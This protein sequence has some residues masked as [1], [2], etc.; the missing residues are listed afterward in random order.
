MYDCTPLKTKCADK[1]KVHDYCEEKLG[2]DICVPIIKIYNKTDEI[3]WEELPD[4]FVIKC[5]HGSGMNIIVKDKKLLNKQDAV[6]KLNIWMRTDFAFQNGY[7]Y[8]YHDIER[9]IFAESFIGKDKGDLVDYKFSC[10][11]GVPKILQVM[12]DRYSGRLRLN[13]YDMDFKPLYCSRNDHPANYNITDEKPNGFDLMVGYSKI[14]SKDFK[15]VR[16]DFYEVNGVVYLGELTF[17]PGS[18]FFKYNDDK[19]SL[20]FGEWL[21]LNKN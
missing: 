19:W 4:R 13:Y 17:T 2:K 18:G 8:H 3:N 11:N 21:D 1:I 16:V 7:E 12:C 10:F 6:N 14:L 9:K 20:L 15:Y 5:N